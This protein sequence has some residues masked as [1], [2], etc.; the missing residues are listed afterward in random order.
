MILFYAA[1][2]QIEGHLPSIDKLAEY[3]E[4][5]ESAA[6]NG[7]ILAA[8]CMAKKFDH[9]LGV[10]EDTALVYAWVQ[11]AR[12]HG[13]HDDVEDELDEWEG[14]VTAVTGE[15]DIVRGNKLLNEMRGRADEM[16]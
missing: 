6:L 16:I 13:T 4:E 10:S 1:S 7:S 5:I 3:Q 8:L 11:W 2:V 12:L 15:A 9:G 14:Y